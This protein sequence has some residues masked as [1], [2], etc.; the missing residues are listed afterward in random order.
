LQESDSVFDAR[1]AQTLKGSTLSGHAS[2]LNG[3][4]EGAKG[5]AI[6]ANGPRTTATISASATI[7]A[8][9]PSELGVHVS[10]SRF[11]CCAV[12]LHFRTCVLAEA[13]AE[14]NAVGGAAGIAP[15]SEIVMLEGK[16]EE[17]TAGERQKSNR[18]RPDFST[19]TKKTRLDDLSDPTLAA[20]AS[21][22]LPNDKGIDERA[23]ERERERE[24]ELRHRPLQRLTHSKS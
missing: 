20:V 2:A 11:V 8:S 12:F 1:A 7:F 14:L 21:E 17:K 5:D 18:G 15:G 3:H 23:S 24:I 13:A 22:Q 19:N 16:K 9:G 6:G 4:A 10:R